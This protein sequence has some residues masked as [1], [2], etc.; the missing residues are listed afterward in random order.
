MLLVLGVEWVHPIL[1][2]GYQALK[3]LGL[4]SPLQ[5]VEKLGHLK[6]KLTKLVIMI[7]QDQQEQQRQVLEVVVEVQPY[8]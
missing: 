3:N 5:L 6:P 4:E 7:N 8:P 2:K 1:L